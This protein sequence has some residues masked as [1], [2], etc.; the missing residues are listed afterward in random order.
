[1]NDDAMSGAY[2]DDEDL[3]AAVAEE[4]ARREAPI[5]LVLRP[6][7]ALQL[8]GLLQLALRHPAIDPNTTRAA[9]MFLE[10]VRAYFADAPAV[11]ELLRRGDRP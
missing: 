5:E 7:S 6:T 1:M 2:R 8:A 11:R 4:M 3:L 9:V 10:H